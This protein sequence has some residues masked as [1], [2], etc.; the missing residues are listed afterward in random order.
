V[1]KKVEAKK[2]DERRYT[3]NAVTIQRNARAEGKR[4][5]SWIAGSVL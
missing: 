1:E 2:L 5:W 3:P 4:S